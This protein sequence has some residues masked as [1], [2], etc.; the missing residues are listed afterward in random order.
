MRKTASDKVVIFLKHEENL[1]FLV[2]RGEA[3]SQYFRRRSWLVQLNK[4]R[5]EVD[6]PDCYITK[7]TNNLR[8]GLNGH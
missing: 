1:A 2:L 5:D 7:F 4:V 8:I 6:I 3:W